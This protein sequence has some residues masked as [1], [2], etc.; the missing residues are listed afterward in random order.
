VRGD[1]GMKIIFD[2][3]KQKETFI[4]T[5]CPCDFD[6]EY[7]GYNCDDCESSMN[8]EKCFEK[9]IEMEVKHD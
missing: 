2:N 1:N 7:P 6:R 4:K 9:Y 5:C 3:E 8:C